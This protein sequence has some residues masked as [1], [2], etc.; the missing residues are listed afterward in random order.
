LA[1]LYPSQSPNTRVQIYDPYYFGE[2]SGDDSLDEEESSS[3][4]ER[5]MIFGSN[6][7]P[8][9]TIKPSIEYSTFIPPFAH[10]N[11][12]YFD[13]ILQEVADASTSTDDLLLYTVLNDRRDTGS[14]LQSL[15]SETGVYRVSRQDADRNNYEELGNV[16]F[17]TVK[18]PESISSSS[19]STIVSHQSPI[20]TDT[21]LSKTTS[22]I[23]ERENPYVDHEE[24]ENPASIYVIPPPPAITREPEGTSTYKSSKSGRST[25]SFL[26]LFSRNKK[27]GDKSTKKKDDDQSSTKKKE[28]KKRKS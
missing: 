15:R 21:Q 6:S 24:Q 18:P 8:K 1:S 12:D 25:R 28:K 11:E 9:L 14:D 13:T 16:P 7:R 23:D 27:K 19:S 17:P 10:H 20:R 2:Q 4:D 5:L 26:S 22:P 3:D